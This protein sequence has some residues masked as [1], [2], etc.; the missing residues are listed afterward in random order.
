MRFVPWTADQLSRFIPYDAADMDVA[1]LHAGTFFTDG[2]KK[3]KG[4]TCQKGSTQ[5]RTNGRRMDGVVC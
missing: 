4:A 5:R 1:I 3:H 2:G